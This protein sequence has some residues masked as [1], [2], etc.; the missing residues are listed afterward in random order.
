MPPIGW[1]LSG[2]D[3]ANLFVLLKKGKK[4]GPYK[5]LSS[6]KDDGAVTINVGAFLNSFINFVVISVVIFTMVRIVNKVRKKKA[7]IKKKCPFCYSKIDHRSVRCS[8]C[9]ASLE[10]N[11][12]SESEES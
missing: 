4:G 12:E 5:S 6:A 11:C 7:K 2:V 8:F 3:F 1:L 9:T 10:S